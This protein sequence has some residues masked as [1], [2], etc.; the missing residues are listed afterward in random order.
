MEL[1]IGTANSFKVKESHWFLEGLPN[2]SIHSLSEILE[3]PEIEEDGETL[4]ENSNKKARIISTFTPHIVLTSD[5]GVAIPGLGKSWD[6]R[7]PKRNVG[8]NRTAEERMIKLLAMMSG[9]SEEQRRVEYTMALSV[10]QNGQILWSKEFFGYSGYIVDK[11]QYIPDKN[12]RWMGSL[13]YIPEFETVEVK[14]SPEQ[15]EK[16]RDQQLPVREELQ[17]YLLQNHS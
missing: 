8:E 1:L 6:Y 10:A 5:A 13:W 15:L 9:L 2:L 12:D 4:L 3:V 7:R 16:L 14:L 11:I 17:K